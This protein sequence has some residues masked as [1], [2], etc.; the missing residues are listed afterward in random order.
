MDTIQNRLGE[1]IPFHYLF[2]GSWRAFRGWVLNHVMAPPRKATN[3]RVTEVDIETG[4]RGKSV[5][6]CKEK[7]TRYDICFRS[8]L[9]I[10]R[11]RYI[12]FAAQPCAYGSPCWWTK[13]PGDSEKSG[14]GEHNESWREA[15]RGE[16]IGGDGPD[17]TR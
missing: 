6:Q 17:R 7:T 3:S 10:P 14:N 4:W 2:L 11:E 5:A 16:E 8:V 1:T 15:K 9:D 12:V 13:Y